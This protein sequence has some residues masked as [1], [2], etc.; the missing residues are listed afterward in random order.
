M[1]QLDREKGDTWPQV[2]KHNF[3]KFGERRCAMRHKHFGVWQPVTWKDYYF[4]VKYLSLGL[5]SLGMAPGDKVLIIGDNAPQWYYAEL[6]AQVNRGVAVGMFA[7][8]PPAEI[9]FIAENSG[10]R[11]AVIEGQE[12]ADKF[13]QIAAALPQLKKIVCWSYKG[14]AKYDQ[15]LWVGWREVL[16]LGQGHEGGHPGAFEQHLAAG[17]ADDV[18]AIIYTA[19]TTG[20]APKGALH[21]HRSLR[22]G[23]EFLLNLDPWTEEDNVVP[24]LPPAWI[25]EQWIGIG[26]HLL[27]GAT[28][29][30]AEAPETQQRD[31]RETGPS[32]V[33]NRARIWESQAAAVQA[34]IFG[35]DAVK[36]WV[37]RRLMPIGFEAAEARYRR[38]PLGLLQK[39]RSAFAD[40]ILFRSIRRSLGLAN[41]RV[42][43]ASGA[44]LSP[45]ALRFYHA[46]NIQLKSLYGSTEGGVLT[47]ARNAEIHPETLGPPGP[48]A[49]LKIGADGE[50]IYRQP[51]AFLGYHDDPEQT[52]AVLK[53][54][55]FHSGDSGILREDGRLVFVDRLR[56]QLALSGGGKLSPQLTESRL[57]FSPYIKDAWVLAGPEAAYPV[58]VIVI[59][60]ESVARWAGQRKVAFSNFAELSQAPEVYGLIRQDL[61]RVNRDLPAGVRVR[62]FVN[63]H[64]EFD[65]DDLE[66]TRTRNLRR[67]VLFER[68]RALIAAVY[69]GKTQIEIETQ[70][71]HR[72]GRM[73]TSRTTLR[74]ESM[75]G[76]GG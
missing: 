42:C 20:A 52:A 55:W 37:C 50:L 61:D 27:S 17:R 10:A 29:N 38:Q 45:D 60:G 57:R 23:A 34:R 22:A 63:L 56:D 62:K 28:L 70:V 3:E 15:E 33:F 4:N 49:E 30:F 53:D 67:T 76:A 21:S 6:A 14:L 69:A 54:G 51:G 18:C 68:Y 65:P 26:C 25:H 73:E 43:Y 40:A 74:I 48:D 47:G 16:A 59:D 58:A 32:I 2:L 11:F 24:Y 44:I 72:D 36:R 9:K 46:L 41:A 1:E 35:A 64:K 31:C 5:L 12:Q 75:E 39:W 8:L 13:L 7:D 19:G 71:R 66:L